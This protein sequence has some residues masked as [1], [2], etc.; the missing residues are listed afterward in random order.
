RPSIALSILSRPSSS[1]TLH[2]AGS[3]E[4]AREGGFFF[5]DSAKAAAGF[6]LTVPAS[7][8]A[9]ADEVIE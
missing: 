2:V 8:L 6:G 3:E 4:A 1:K 5:G 7:V 9:R